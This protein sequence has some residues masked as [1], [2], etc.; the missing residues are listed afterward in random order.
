MQ[1]LG[2]E[3]DG[4][5]GVLDLVGQAPGDLG[6]GGGALGD[7]EAGDVVEHHHPAAAGAVGQAG[8]VE[9]QG[10]GAA[11]GV[12]EF[13]L[14]VPVGFG[15][16]EAVEEGVAEGRVA[17]P[18]GEA[19]VL[20]AVQPVV[21]DG[22]RAVVGGP[23]VAVR[24][25]G[26]HARREAGEHALEVGAVALDGGAAV[27]GLGAGVLELARHLVEGLGQ[28]AQLVVGGQG[29]AL[30]EVAG[31]D[32]LGA[33]GEDEQRR[34]QAAGE[35][36]GH[37]HR[38]EQREQQGE[39][40]GE[41]VDALQA[42]AGEGQLLVVAVHRLDALGVHREG[43]GDVLGDLQ[44]LG[45]AEAARGDRHDHPQQQAVGGVPLGGPVAAALAGV[46]ELGGGGLL[47]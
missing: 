19:G 26:Q 29:L 34:R 13:E 16:G 46:A 25:K 9:Q 15:G 43:L 14:A 5:E 6:P 28:H 31:G 42:V 8:A 38:G 18:V 22:H 11:V 10:L 45:F 33:F 23:Q 3:L 24:R 41:G 37:R 47:G 35:H 40:Q 21:E 17:L 30:A 32:G 27:V 20:V 7:D 1:P 36:E 12:G 39:R 44:Q 2:G 4:G